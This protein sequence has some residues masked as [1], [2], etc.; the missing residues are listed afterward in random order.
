MKLL[1]CIIFLYVSMYNFS[2]IDTLHF[3]SDS[4]DFFKSFIDTLNYNDSLYFFKEDSLINGFEN[5][6]IDTLLNT[7]ESNKADTT[8]E[9]YL[10][11]EKNFNDSEKINL[12]VYDDTLLK[13]NLL[14]SLFL[15][16]GFF[17]YLGDV[18]DNYYLHP[19][20]GRSGLIFGVSKKIK[21]NLYLNFN[22]INGKLAGNYHNKDLYIN[23]ETN[24]LVGSIY[25][26]YNF[27]HFIDSIKLVKNKYISPYIGIGFEF[28]NFKSK[29]DLKDAN[30][31]YYYPWSDGTL[32]NIPESQADEINAKI[33]FRDYVYETDLREINID[34]FGT[35]PKYSFALPINFSFSFSFSSRLKGNVGFNYHLCFSDYIDNVTS[36]S[37]GKRKGNKFFDSFVFNYFSITFDFFSSHKKIVNES[38]TPI[39]NNNFLKNYYSNINIDFNKIDNFDEDA[40]GVIDLYDLCPKT[41]PN[42]KVDENGCPID[43]DEDGI[44]DYLDEEI[45]SPKGAIVN[46][47]GITIKNDEITSIVK[48]I[49]DTVALNNN[50]ICLFYPSM[51]GNEMKKSYKKFKTFFE[52]LPEKVKPFDVDNDGILSIEEVNLIID[53]FFD[54]IIDLTIEDIYEII[55]IFFS[56]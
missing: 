31:Y 29:G 32:R 44:P 37:K 33:L 51:C 11:I 16:Y 35:Y 8:L 43:S 50:E 13:E 56:Q 3:N 52:H 1:F 22:V 2:Q 10:V 45:N 23:F 42:V 15:G 28:F 14:P 47:K 6:R 26:N 30:G 54:G 24:I 18:K 12:F 25:L 27:K 40:D 38:N 39:E 4:L 41:P 9:N 48:N 46:E 20:I 34:G 21:E 53:K 7:N 17:T 19:T 36:S 49:L 55:E 5:L